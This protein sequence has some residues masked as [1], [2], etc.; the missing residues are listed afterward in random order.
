MRGHVLALFLGAAAV[1]PLPRSAHAAFGALDEATDAITALDVARA[2]P[3]LDKLDA[4]DPPVALQ[5]ARLA[6]YEGEC[7]KAVAELA[8]PGVDK[9]KAYKELS[10]VAFGCARG[11]AGTLVVE[12]ATWGV[13]VRLQDEADAALVPILGET[14]HKQ[15]AVLEKDL[16]VTMPK[17]IRVDL[18]RDQFT[19]SAMTGLPYEAAKQTGTVGIAKFGRVIM[20]SP[21]AMGAS[22]YGF[23]DTLAHELTHLALSRGSLDRAPLWLQEGVAKREEAKWRA[24]TPVDSVSSPDVYAA[25]GLA[26][27]LGRPLD[28][29]GP[30]VAMLPTA[31]EAAVVYAEVTSFV[32]FLAGDRAGETPTA[33]TDATVLPRLVKALATAKDVDAAL[34]EVT[35]KDLKAWDAI[36]RP[37]VMAKKGLPDGAYPE[38]GAKPKDARALRNALRLGELLLAR[39]HVGAARK[40]LEPLSGETKE[41]WIVAWVARSR[42]LSGDPLGAR[43][44][45]D[46]AKIGADAG[47]FWAVR[48]DALRAAG[49]TGSA[50]VDSYLQAIAHAPFLLEAACG[51][52]DVAP[53]PTEL[54]GLA[55]TVAIALCTAAKT[56]APKD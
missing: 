15:L 12:D 18:V 5:R 4:N 31:Q 44:L 8:K 6:L 33:P 39:K 46:P 50:V 11:S 51:W 52:S 3:L 38:K 37:W 30:S 14:I 34:V 28:G 26:A 56:D 36:W 23:R 22:G 48:G 1:A 24:A 29:I 7:G 19:L 10:P 55:R 40:E 43:A 27:G 2:R 54:P 16:G 41:P 42:L 17:P 21:R 25:K 35:G 20:L 47:I 9:L 45:L 13:R 53:E 49:V 32:R